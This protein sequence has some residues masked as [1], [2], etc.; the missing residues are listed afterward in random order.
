MVEG[1]GYFSTKDVR[2]RANMARNPGQ[3][4]LEATHIEFLNPYF[5]NVN[6]SLERFP[7]VEAKFTQV[8]V[9]DVL[10]Q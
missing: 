9:F 2:V 3:M 4:V 5:N 1:E 10:D 7:N 8:I 6:A